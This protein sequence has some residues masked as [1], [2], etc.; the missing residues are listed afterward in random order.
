MRS[1]PT[2]ARRSGSHLRA[3]AQT[4]A[5]VIGV[6]ERFCAAFAARDRAALLELFASDPDVAVVTSEQ[7]VLR[8]Q[9][10]LAAFVDRYVNGPTT[11]SWE[12]RRC[13]VSVAGTAAWLLANGTETAAHE[14]RRQQHPYRMT[15]LLERRHDCWLLMQVHG[16][17]PH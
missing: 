12:W 7:P 15:M 2:V 10:E 8:G 3:D 1:G 5:E 11:Y 16:S 9:Q 6:L 14:N 13:E 4:E 17:S